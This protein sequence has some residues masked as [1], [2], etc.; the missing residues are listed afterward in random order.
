MSEH[1]CCWC[2]QSPAGMR[3]YSPGGSWCCVDC[4]LATDE[5]FDECVG[6]F[7]AL[8]DA[9]EAISP[10]GIVA[11]DADG[12]R[13]YDLV[14]VADEFPVFPEK[15]VTDFDPLGYPPNLRSFINALGDPTTYTWLDES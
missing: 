13:P 5:R 7:H 14:D 12:P 8:I 3:P 2:G 4:A 11:I 10:S 9:A 15:F 1:V 6:R